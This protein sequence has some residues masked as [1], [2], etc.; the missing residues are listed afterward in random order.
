MNDEHDDALANSTDSE[1]P[2][3]RHLKE[4]RKRHLGDGIYRKQ[5]S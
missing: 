1:S 4:H 3:I 2:D 5:K